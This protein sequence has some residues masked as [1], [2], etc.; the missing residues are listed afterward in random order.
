MG[1][2]LLDAVLLGA[3]AVW[4]ARPA[5]LLWS[6]VFVGLAVGVVAVRRR[7]RRRLNEIARARAQLRQELRA[8]MPQRES[9]ESA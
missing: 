1:F 6:A 5:L 7:Y 4:D 3:V 8:V 2:L 9:G